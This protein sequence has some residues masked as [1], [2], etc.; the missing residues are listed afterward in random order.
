MGNRRHNSILLVTAAAFLWC[1]SANADPPPEW[2]LAGSKPQA[3]EVGVET[4]ADRAVEF[5]FRNEVTRQVRMCVRRQKGATRATLDG[6][7]GHF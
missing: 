5:G 6:R 3:Y 2:S 4:A 1:V 7:Y